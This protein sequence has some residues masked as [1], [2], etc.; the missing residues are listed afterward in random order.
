MV[1]SDDATGALPPG[2]HARAADHPPTST[3]SCRLA[4]A[5]GEVAELLLVEVLP[6]GRVAALGPAQSLPRRVGGER[7]PASV[8][9]RVFTTA[10]RVA[11]V[12]E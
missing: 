6:A 12:E 5:V 1:H 9:A 10:W 8:R 2:G 3:R 4:R 11:A 7:S